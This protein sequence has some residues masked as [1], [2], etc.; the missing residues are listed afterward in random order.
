MWK[1]NKFFEYNKHTLKV[2]YVI[3]ALNISEI[4][5]LNYKNNVCFQTGFPNTPPSAIMA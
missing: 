4:T 1:C 5:K 2:K 3:A